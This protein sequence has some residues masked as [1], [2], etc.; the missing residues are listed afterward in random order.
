MKFHPLNSLLFSD[1]TDNYLFCFSP[2]FINSWYLSSEFLSSARASSL[3]FLSNLIFFSNE[4]DSG[5]LNSSLSNWI[6]WVSKF[7][8]KLPG[9]SE[10]QKAKAEL[11]EWKGDQWCF[12]ENFSQWL[13]FQ[14]RIC[15]EWFK[16]TNWWDN[17]QVNL[18][19]VWKWEENLWALSV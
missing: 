16:K 10:N 4:I 1:K 8:S 13:W 2:F 18:A 5:D 14:S 3:F 17:R 19:R 15:F 11:S 7:S 12:E 6:C 9:I